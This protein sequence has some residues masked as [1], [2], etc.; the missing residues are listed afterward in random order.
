[1]KEGKRPP[2]ERRVGVDHFFPFG[3]T[4]NGKKSSTRGSEML[5]WVF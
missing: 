4:G 1:M 2:W 5:I 3:T